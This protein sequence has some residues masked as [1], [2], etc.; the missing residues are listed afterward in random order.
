[1][2]YLVEK[3]KIP[4]VSADQ[5]Y[6][7]GI[8]FDMPEEEYHQIPYFSRSV[9]DEMIFDPS[10]EEHWHNSPM[11]PDYEPMQT[12]AAMELGK[13]IHC[14]LL[15]PDRFDDLYVK[16]PTIDDFHGKIIFT[17][18]DEIKH[19]LGEVGEKKTGNKPELIQRALPY[20]DPH[21]HIIW[22][23]V[24]QAFNEDVE[25]NNKRVLSGDDIAILEGIRES[26]DRRPKMPELFT[27]TL[28]EITIIWKDKKTGIMCKCRLDGA[29]PEAIA[30]VKSFAVKGGKTLAKTMY[31]AI[32]Y[33]RYNF[34]Y[35]VYWLAL[36]TIIERINA[37]KAEVFGEVDPDWLKEFLKN[38]DKQFFIAFFRTQAPYQCKAIEMSKAD[39][40]GATSNVYFTEAET[41]WR[42]AI[43][44]YQDRFI[45][46]GVS[47]WLDE[48]D[49]DKLQDENVPTIMYQNF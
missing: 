40:P 15:E 5:P 46:Y 3:E 26:L 44:L 36:K 31:D 32:N 18:S 24:L 10:G 16:K 27:N 22:E 47:R 38:P 42:I 1:M 7:E 2:C 29:R 17:T 12:T 48:K 20:L 34:Q 33:E 13:A 35:Y 41:T 49:I 9:A 37:G 11:N 30:E 14:L 23:N 8:Y 28:S 19:F 4:E 25:A 21:T 6:A 39:S 43:E 45:K